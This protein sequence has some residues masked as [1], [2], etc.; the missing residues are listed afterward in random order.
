MLAQK[1]ASCHYLVVVGRRGLSRSENGYLFFNQP[2]EYQVGQAFQPDV[3]WFTVRLESLT[4]S[5]F[6]V[7]AGGCFF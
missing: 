5:S 2:P 4:Y 6:D 1:L 7:I 3:A